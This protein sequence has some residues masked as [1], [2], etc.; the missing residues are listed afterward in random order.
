MKRTGEGKRQHVTK[1]LMNDD[2]FARVQS[3]AIALG[4]SIPRTLVEAAIGV[5]PLTRTERDR[6]YAEVM[7]VRRLL[8]NATNNLNQVARALNSDV[9]V[10]S[11]QIAGVLRH[12]ARAVQRL[13][14]TASRYAP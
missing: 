3:R 13:D 10:P 5:P 8:G 4:V 14:E 12:I 1:V 6:M 11:E 2:E 7:A 9:E